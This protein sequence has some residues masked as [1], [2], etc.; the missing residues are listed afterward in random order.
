MKNFF[1]VISNE[2]QL[3]LFVNRNKANVESSTFILLGADFSTD[4]I[5]KYNHFFY[6]KKLAYK[7][8]KIISNTTSRFIWSWFLNPQ[9]RDISSYKNLSLGLS[10][11]SSL[12]SLMNLSLKYF[13]F[14]KNFLK[15]YHEIFIFEDTDDVFIQILLFFKKKKGYK[16]NIIK[17]KHKTSNISFIG[18]RRN[19]EG[20]FPDKKIKNVLLNSIIQKKNYFNKSVF[21]LPGGT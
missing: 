13:F 10:F 21:F 12:E 17:T 8:K 15:E 3:D 9:K 16:L 1:F 19:L 2:Y 11:A 6:D 4:K 5:K 14:L 18:A 20:L 7:Q